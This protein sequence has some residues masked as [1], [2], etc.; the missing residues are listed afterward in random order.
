MSIDP[1]RPSIIRPVIIISGFVIILAGIKATAP[2]MGLFF[3]AVFLAITF[4]PGFSWL[5]NKGVPS[6]VT[7]LILFASITGFALLLFALA[8]FPLSQMDEKLPL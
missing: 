3:L 6:S 5:R 1:E 7:V 8:W 2:I 4:A